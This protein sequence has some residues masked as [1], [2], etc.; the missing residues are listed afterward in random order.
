MPP[1]KLRDLIRQIRATKTAADER[2]VITKECALIRTAIRE[3]EPEYRCRNVAKLLYIHM[4]GFPAHFGQLECLKLVASPRFVDKRI[5]YLGVALLLDEKAEIGLL[6]TNCLKN[7]MCSS[8]QYIVGLALSTFGSIASP[9]MCR[10]L[11]SEVEKLLKSSNAFVRKKAALAAVRI[12][13]KVPE[14]VENFVPGTRALLGER[15]HAV[16]LTG[17]TLMNEICAISH[18]SLVH[19]R[20]LVPHLIRIL[21]ALQVAGSSAEHDVGGI[22]DPFLQVKVLR[23][24]RMLAKD[25]SES[26]EALNDL[27][28]QIATNTDTVK[29]VGNSILYETVL[30]IMDIRSE[31]GLRVLAVNIL[32]RFLGNSDKNI[33]YVALNTLLKIVHADQTAVQRHR[34]TI[35]ECLKDSDVTIRRR[36]VELLLALVNQANIRALAQELLLFLE[37]CES[38]FKSFLTTEL[39]LVAERYSPSRR[40][41]IDTVLRIITMAGAFVRDDSVSSLISLI[42]QTPELQGYATLHLYQALQEDIIQQPLVQVA[43]WCIGEY[44]DLLVSGEPSTEEPPIQIPESD[45]LSLIESILRSPH[46]SVITKEFSINALIK[47]TTR[48]S[49]GNIDRIRNVLRFFSRSLEVELQQRSAEYSN[50][51]I[52][53]HLRAPLLERMPVLVSHIAEHNENEGIVM[54]EPEQETINPTAIAASYHAAAQA[55]AA[56]APASFNGGG[57]S[58]LDL[59]DSGF[60]GSATPAATSFGGG[61]AAAGGFGMGAAPSAGAGHD[62]LDLLGGG[63]GASAPGPTA[64]VSQPAASS[65][66]DIMGDFSSPVA[67]APA[68]NPATTIVAYEKNG[69]RITFDLS[70]DPASGLLAIHVTSVNQTANA[71]N[72]FVFQAAAPKSV[73]LTMMQPSD[74]HLVPGGRVVQDM[75]VDNPT[76]RPLRFRLKIN[77]TVNQS[78]VEVLDEVS[79][80]PATFV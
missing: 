77:F 10:D 74:A 21:K 25:D 56:A 26:S 32:G 36:A 14:L 2:A 52:V 8:N 4:L 28:A 44:G 45:V 46:S 75:Q 24:L 51:F 69:L 54:N 15:N 37:N 70:Q 61:A 41:H 35:L 9:E 57:S 5:G 55:A 3:E 73:K 18:D 48:L 23:L 68:A 40:W 7:D 58:L 79:N 71:F 38:E 76:H 42:T 43:V 67:A 19:F 6:V 33:R 30:C 12:V 53:D 66:L 17:V 80:F 50:M 47:L 31:T 78:P 65:L 62:M 39:F 60:G 27:L 29:N 16:L 34:N 72:N 49:A 1:S 22:T 64:P 63:F 13:R 59:L 11:A 20:K